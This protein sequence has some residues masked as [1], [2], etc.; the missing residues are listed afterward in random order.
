MQEICRAVNSIEA[1]RARKL[2]MHEDKRSGKQGRFHCSESSN[3]NFNARR[4]HV[5][6]RCCA[7]KLCICIHYL[8]VNSWDQDSSTVKTKTSGRSIHRGY[9][10]AHGI[11]HT[12]YTCNFPLDTSIKLGSSNIYCK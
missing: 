7:Q 1:E 12:I 8:R 11:R 3:K 2:K 5:Y 9:L 4:L 10:C 6:L